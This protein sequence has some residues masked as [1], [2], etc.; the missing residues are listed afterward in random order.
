M[1]ILQV[2][3]ITYI[4]KTE[5]KNL[6]QALRKDGR[7]IKATKIGLSFSYISKNMQEILVHVIKE[8]L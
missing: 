5:N 3:T 6:E 2:R 1:R 7:M 8:G 4:I